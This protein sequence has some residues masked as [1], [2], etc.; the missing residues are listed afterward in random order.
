[1]N[2]LIFI[3]LFQFPILLFACS[4]IGKDS[5]V[6]SIKYSDF[7]FRGKVIAK[8]IITIQDDSLPNRFK[9]RR[10]EYSFIETEVYKGKSVSDTIKV[11][12]GQGHGDCGFTFTIGADYIV[13]SNYENKYYKWGT[14]INPFLTT[15]ICKRT[16]LYSEKEN[17]LIKLTVRKLHK[18]SKGKSNTQRENVALFFESFLTDSNF[19][20]AR[21]L[22]PLES[23]IEDKD[24]KEEDSYITTLLNNYRVS[25]NQQESDFEAKEESKNNMVIVLKGKQTGLLVEH[26]FSLRNNQW[27][28]EK[29]RDL[30][31]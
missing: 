6:N 20:K 16:Q 18:Q 9:M 27:Y 31:K 19:Q 29:I 2:R 8:Q 14:I 22:Y 13:Y 4:C 12:T 15:N 11:I 10:V 24:S 5:I 7:V 30:S 3:I 23:E 21:I 26:Y 17:K 25:F 28:L 1:M